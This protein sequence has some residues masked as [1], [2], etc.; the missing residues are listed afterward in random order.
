LSEP[1]KV[2]LEVIEGDQL[3]SLHPCGP[4]PGPEDLD[5]PDYGWIE[6]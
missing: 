4:E 5:D 2:D 6:G 3:L 1:V